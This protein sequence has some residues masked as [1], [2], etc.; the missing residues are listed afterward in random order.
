VHLAKLLSGFGATCPKTFNTISL[1][2]AVMSQGESKRQQLAIYLHDEHQRT[3]DGLRVRA[4]F[5]P[6]SLAG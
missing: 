1:T 2:K 5:T 3:A 4:I 6:D